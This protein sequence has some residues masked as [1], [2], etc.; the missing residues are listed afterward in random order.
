[1]RFAPAVLRKLTRIGGRRHSKKFCRESQSL[2]IYHAG[3]H[4]KYPSGKKFNRNIWFELSD[5]V[6][7]DYFSAPDDNF[8]TRTCHF[9]SKEAHR[10]IDKHV[11]KYTTKKNRET[12]MTNKEKEKIR[13][14]CAE[15]KHAC[16]AEYLIKEKKK[17]ERR[18]EKAAQKRIDKSNTAL[19]K[20][21]AQIEKLEQENAELRAELKVQAEREVPDDAVSYENGTLC[22]EIDE[23]DKQ[24]VEACEAEL[25][26]DTFLDRYSSD[27]ALADDK[28][29]LVD[30]CIEI[31]RRKH[32]ANASA[33]Y[34]SVSS[35]DDPTLVKRITCVKNCLQQAFDL[36]YLS[37]EEAKLY[38]RAKF[39]MKIELDQQHAIDWNKY[40][41]LERVDW[42][43][44]LFKEA[45]EAIARGEWSC[46]SQNDAE[47]VRDRHE[48]L[49]N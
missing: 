48:T 31:L 24:L 49:E 42:R 3:C 14:E 16:S 45:D 10:F 32:E 12:D 47:M 28:E 11:Y 18:A 13:Q 46:A 29:A 21:L 43:R 39:G 22:Y 8:N 33:P 20:A 23:Q 41:T 7:K 19:V 5:K 25:A 17:A 4:H 36:S 38:L 15:G 9:L 40:Q 26:R 2:F 34:K 30:E 44:K 1:M 35:I 27:Y 6:L 37:F